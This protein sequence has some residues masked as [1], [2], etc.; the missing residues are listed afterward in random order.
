MLKRLRC[1][2]TGE[3]TKKSG[4]AHLAGGALGGLSACVLLQPLDLVSIF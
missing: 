1:K 4:S 3:M 2:I